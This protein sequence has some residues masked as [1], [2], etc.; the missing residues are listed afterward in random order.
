MG[1]FEYILII[2]KDVNVE[3]VVN[4][5]CFSSW[6]SSVVF[7]I[8]NEYGREEICLILDP[9]SFGNLYAGALRQFAIERMG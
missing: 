4:G 1:I 9:K 2:S 5:V 8:L 3:V 7:F 6:I